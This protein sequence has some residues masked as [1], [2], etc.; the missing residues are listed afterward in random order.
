[1]PVNTDPKIAPHESFPE[2]M[3]KDYGADVLTFEAHH[4]VVDEKGRKVGGRANI[5]PQL[6]GYAVTIQGT[7]DG[8][9]FGSS[10]RATYYPKLERARAAAAAKLNVQRIGFRLKYGVRP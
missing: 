2:C 9:A 8:V 7:R 4:G 10:R 3:V 5:W 1:M 6:G